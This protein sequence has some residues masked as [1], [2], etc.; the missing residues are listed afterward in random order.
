MHPSH[1]TLGTG[2]EMYLS[3]SVQLCLYKNY[4]NS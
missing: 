1:S 4:C 2:M 3:M